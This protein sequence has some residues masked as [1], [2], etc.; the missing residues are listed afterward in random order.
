MSQASVNT[1]TSS[2]QI[3]KAMDYDR[4]RS[5][6][7]LPDSNKFKV[8][9]AMIWVPIAIGVSVAAGVMTTRG[10]QRIFNRSSGPIAANGSSRITNVFNNSAAA[11]SRCSGRT[12]TGFLPYSGDF[13]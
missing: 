2:N 11:S 4:E 5:L 9:A 6:N 13:K 12:F 10:L 1:T 7:G 8:N 3:E